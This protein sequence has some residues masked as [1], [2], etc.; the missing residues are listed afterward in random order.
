VD[1][2]SAIATLILVMDPLGNIPLFLSILRNVPAERRRKVLVREIFI[3]Y[4]VL[5]A[6]L[7][8]GRYVLGFLQLDQETIS[9]SGGIVLFLI[10][11]RMIFPQDQ[12]APTEPE[13]EPFVVPLATPLFAGPSV[14]A[15]LL[16]LQKSQPESLALL[17]LAM[18]SAWAVSGT[19][20]LASALF[21]RLLGDR[22]LIAMERLMGMVLVMA[23]VQMFL[24]GLRAYLR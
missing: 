18:T 2:Y 11:I 12:S 9:V 6:F 16:L 19:I 23:A 7:M 10:A 15:L 13:G 20:L 4:F 24:N 22:G 21:Y 3:A 5:L 14:L 1:L 17:L 8:F